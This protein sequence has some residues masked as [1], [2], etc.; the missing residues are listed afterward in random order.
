M[1]H[2]DHLAVAGVLFSAVRE[3][4]T[5]GLA[6]VASLLLLDDVLI[7]LLLFGTL[8]DLLSSPWTQ[9]QWG[10][11]RK[12]PRR[13]WSD[14]GA[15]LAQNAA[16][17]LVVVSLANAFPALL[18]WSAEISVL[19]CAMRAG[20]G[21]LDHVLPAGHPFRAVWA[22][23]QTRVERLWDVIDG[24]ADEEQPDPR[25]AGR[26]PAPPDTAGDQP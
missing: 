20:T 21:T 5:A 17:L 25:G 10:G 23:I 1:T 12:I 11:I 2:R 15:R 6:A 19:Y 16:I 9:G 13:A 26:P 18:G 14:W 24:S 22:R 7:R 8:I 3:L 4:L